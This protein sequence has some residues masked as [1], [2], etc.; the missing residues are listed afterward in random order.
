MLT[1]ESITDAQIRALRE[2]L[3]RESD[4]QFT[5]DVDE[6]G[7]ALWDLNKYPPHLKPIAQV[8]KQLARERC[9]EILNTR[10]RT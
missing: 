6:T 9:A 4:N 10:N 2:V 8:V 5:C 3:L 1:A 7:M